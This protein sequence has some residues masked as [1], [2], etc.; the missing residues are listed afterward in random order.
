MIAA[1]KEHQ[2]LCLVIEYQNQNVKWLYFSHA[3]SSGDGW[4][5]TL[6]SPVLNLYSVI[7]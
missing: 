4:R 2:Q 7:R 3:G 5:R 6:V 1:I